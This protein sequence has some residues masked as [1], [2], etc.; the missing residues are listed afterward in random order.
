MKVFRTQGDLVIDITRSSVL[1]P[2]HISDLDVS[3]SYLRLEEQFLGLYNKAHG[4]NLNKLP[5]KLQKVV[6]GLVA[7]MIRQSVEKAYEELDMPGY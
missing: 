6:S 7:D 5:D 3:A 4:T 2:T 1:H